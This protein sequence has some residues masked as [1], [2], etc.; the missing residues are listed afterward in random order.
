MAV[1]DRYYRFERFTPQQ[2]FRWIDA[3]RKRPIRMDGY[4][5]DGIM[6]N[7]VMT[8]HHGGCTCVACGRVGTHFFAEADVYDMQLLKWFFNPLDNPIPTAHLNLYGYDP[9]GGEFMI[10]SDHVVPK[11]RGGDD[12]VG[13]RVP[14]CA[15]CNFIK[16]NDPDWLTDLPKNSKGDLIHRKNRQL[17]I[18]PVEKEHAH[19]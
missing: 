2:V 17:K 11:S 16:G 14:L 6:S 19:A 1:G 18:A 8:Y 7:R 5:I 15:S 12:G 3:G 9:G 10:T 4:R 13:N